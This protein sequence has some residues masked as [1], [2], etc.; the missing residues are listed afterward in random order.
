MVIHRPRYDARD[1]GDSHPRL[2]GIE[3]I[4]YQT[5]DTQIGER[6]LGYSTPHTETK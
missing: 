1:Y 3:I 6:F 4:I 5:M 2:W